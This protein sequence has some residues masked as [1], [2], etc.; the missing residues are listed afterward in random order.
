MLRQLPIF[1]R[2][3]LAVIKKIIKAERM[4]KRTR[5]SKQM[6]RKLILAV[7]CPTCGVAPGKFCVLY[8]GDLRTEP[9]P[10]RK[11]AASEAIEMR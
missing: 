11:V 1:E 7:P 8:S 2:V 5:S 6:R 10:N 3:Q 9:H 4:P